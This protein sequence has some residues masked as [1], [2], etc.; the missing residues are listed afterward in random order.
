MMT[1]EKQLKLFFYWMNE[2]ERI[3]LV[4]KEGAPWPWTKDKILQ[5]Y[6]FTNVFRRFDRTTVDLVTRVKDIKDPVELYARICLFRLFNWTP[7]YDNI[8]S[9]FVGDWRKTRVA[10]KASRDL[11]T[12]L[13]TGA[14]MIHADPGAK[15]DKVDSYIDTMEAIWGLRNNFADKIRLNNTLEY[16]TEAM[17]NFNH[18]GAFIA[19]ELACDFGYFKPLLL[20][21]TDKMTWAN[22]GPGAARGIHRIM[23]GSDRKPHNG[24]DYVHDMRWLLEYSEDAWEHERKLEMRDIEH[25]LCEFDKYCRVYFEEGRSPKQ[26]Y[27]HEESPPW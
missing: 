11:G 24:I 6:K 9:K 18:I 13:W 20:K 2:R 15:R 12:Q 17:Q 5:T 1:K 16:A 19:Y 22:T 10:L 8:T 25:S 27:R 21:A 23:T 3:R 26:K 14:Y 4:K 7:T